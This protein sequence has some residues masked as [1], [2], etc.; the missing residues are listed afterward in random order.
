MRKNRPTETNRKAIFAAS[1]FSFTLAILMAMLAG[2]FFDGFKARTWTLNWIPIKGEI[3]EMRTYG[4]IISKWGKEERE[5]CFKYEFDGAVYR[6]YEKHFPLDPVRPRLNVKTG[7]SIT[8]YVNPLNPR[9]LVIYRMDEDDFFWQVIDLCGLVL[10]ASCTFFISMWLLRM[11]IV[12][13]R[14]PRPASQRRK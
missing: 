9:Q 3:V 12:Y 13:G 8:I 10:A 1:F 6:H 2:D 14:K 5:F 11:G 7:D 4:K